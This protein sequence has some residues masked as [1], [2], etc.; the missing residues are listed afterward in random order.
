MAK[1]YPDYFGYSTFMQYGPL[2]SDE[3]SLVVVPT[4]TWTT[5]HQINSKGMTKG[6]YF[7]PQG[8]YSWPYPIVRMT[9]DNAAPFEIDTG[10]MWGSQAFS[11]NILPVFI[12]QWLYNGEYFD[13]GIASGIT[14]QNSFLLEFYH[15]EGANRLVNSF[16]Y[17]TVVQ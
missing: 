16:V 9:I 8:A 12:T 6:G 15:S 3:Q 11:G 14:F 13:C 10:E 1:G 7:D 4:A 17:Y 2:L 5:I